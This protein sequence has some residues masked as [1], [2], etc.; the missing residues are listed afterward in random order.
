MDVG[1]LRGGAGGL[2]GG[3][4][5]SGEAGLAVAPSPLGSARSAPRANGARPTPSRSR[6]PPT[7]AGIELKF[8]DAQQKQENQIKAHPLLHRAEG[9]RDR[10]LAGGRDRLGHRAARRPRPPSIPVILTDRARRRAGRV[11]VRDAS[12]ARTSSRKAARPAR[13]L[14]EQR[15]DGRATSTSSSCRAPSA[16]RPPSTARRAS[17]KS[18]RPTP[19]LQ[20]HPLADRRLHPRQGQGGDGS[21][22]QGRGQEDQRAV[23]RTTTTW[24]SA[25]SRPSRKR[26]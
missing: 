12:S 13:W 16:R 23:T 17:R 4:E 14:V 10:L 19:R 21:L 24:R 25:P 3:G 5:D 8:S 26:A 9:R 7:E 18:S 22:P 20:D 1:V 15:K 6:R 11:A 2:L